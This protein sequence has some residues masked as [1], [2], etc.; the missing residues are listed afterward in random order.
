MDAI[1]GIDIAMVKSE[2]ES[3][4]VRCIVYVYAIPLCIYVP[5]HMDGEIHLYTIAQSYTDADSVFC[6]ALMSMRMEGIDYQHFR[7]DLPE[8][9][10]GAFFAGPP[11]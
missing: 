4:M 1:C 11:G 10:G 6:F 8:D 9:R 5:M 7:C 2:S 3:H